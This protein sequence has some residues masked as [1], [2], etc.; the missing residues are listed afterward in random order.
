MKTQQIDSIEFLQAKY[1]EFD[2]EVFNYEREL[3]H[4]LLTEKG[5]NMRLQWLTGQIEMI[6]ERSQGR[7]DK[8]AEKAKTL[9]CKTVYLYQN[10][11]K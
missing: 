7:E 6:I 2:K 4:E 10:S 1:N 9:Y 5:K 11:T 3:E 8:L